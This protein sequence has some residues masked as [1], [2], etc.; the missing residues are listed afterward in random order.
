MLFLIILFFSAPPKRASINQTI[1]VK[2]GNACGNSAS[3]NLNGITIL[4]CPRIGENDY[5]VPGLQV[6]PNPA[7]NELNVLFNT[8]M[9]ADYLLQ[10][11]D[12]TG[13][14]VIS[15]KG[16]GTGDELHRILEVSQ[17]AKGS[18]IIQLKTEQGTSQKSIVLQ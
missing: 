9:D 13:R 8:T 18:Y 2:A 10:L 15:D 17:L 1:A 7:H 16:K 14:I 12:V 5:N 11:M 6:Y 4:S 3:R